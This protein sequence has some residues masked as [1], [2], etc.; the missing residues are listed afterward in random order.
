[1]VIRPIRPEDERLIVS[2]HAKLS[3]RSI[4]QRYFHVLTLDQRVSHDRLV[5][6]CFGDYDRE[7]ALVAEWSDPS[8]HQ[9]EILA[10]GRLSKAHL[11]NEAELA[12]LI[13]DE[14]QGRGL[15]TELSRRLIEIARS[16]KL[17]RVTVEVLGANR[18]ML[19][20]CRLLGFD[21]KHIE[22]GVVHG[23]LIL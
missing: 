13:E 22:D 21:L 18:Q 3:E 7:I 10:V 16:E 11:L 14:Y 5:K 1:V 8:T 9:K 17:D 4:Y 23:V 12:V 19:E 15:G 6:V 2:F 20:V